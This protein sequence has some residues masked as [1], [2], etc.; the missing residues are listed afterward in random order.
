MFPNREPDFS[1]LLKV[2]TRD[3]EPDVL[4]FYELFADHEIMEAILGRP[5]R[6]TED[7]VEYMVKCG[8][9]YVNALI[10]ELHFPTESFAETDDTAGTSREKRLFRISNRSVIY[11]WDDFERY[12]WPDPAKANYSHIE[13]LDRL[14]PDGMKVM[15][16]TGFVL[17]TAM[18][19]LG[20]EELC[21]LT[22]DDPALL[23]AIFQEI[24]EILEHIYIVCAQMDAVGAMLIQDD[25]GFKTGT[26]I[27]PEALRRWVFPWY[28]RYADIC[29]EYGKPVLLHSCGNLREVMDDI[30]DYCKIDAKHSY[31][32]QIQPVTEA[33]I[34]YGD[35]ISIIGG[36]DVHFLCTATEDEVRKRTRETLEVCMPGGGFALG[37]GNSVA[38]Y[39]PVRNFL[40]ML[41]EGN[42]LGKYHR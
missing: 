30:I 28:K 16:H 32:D 26:M 2:F 6:T 35:R 41:D 1:R 22:L 8:Y 31:E 10:T 21:Y 7:Y 33:K 11:S 19:I 39:I 37:T 29:H 14:I 27:S 23:D 42:K 36:I 15:V 20:Y 24:G 5:I 18:A 25:L 40:A 4:P 3:G 12:P 9:D 13:I 38:N 17:E 34:E